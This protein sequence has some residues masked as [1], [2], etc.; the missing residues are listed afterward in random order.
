MAVTTLFSRY[1]GLIVR[2]ICGLCWFASWTIVAGI[3][4]TNKTPRQF[5]LRVN[6]H[7]SHSGKNNQDFCLFL[8]H[9]LDLTFASQKE[10]NV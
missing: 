6:K 5:A 1:M 10:K 4:R 8:N 3:E 2:V 7:V 9:A